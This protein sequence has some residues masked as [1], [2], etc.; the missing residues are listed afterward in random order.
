MLCRADPVCLFKDLPHAQAGPLAALRPAPLWQRC[1]FIAPGFFFQVA[2]SQCKK[3][4]PR[5]L[6]QWSLVSGEGQGQEVAILCV[7]GDRAEDTGCITM[8]LRGRAPLRGPDAI[9]YLCPLFP[10]LLVS[11]WKAVPPGEANLQYSLRG[12]A[13]DFREK[14]NSSSIIL[15]MQ[16]LSVGKYSTGSICRCSWIF[17]LRAHLLA[18]THTL[19]WREFILTSG[20]CAV[21]SFQNR[22]NYTVLKQRTDDCAPW[23]GEVWGRRWCGRL[24]HYLGDLLEKQTDDTTTACSAWISSK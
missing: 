18:P 3:F 17:L 16:C 8:G 15:P 7:T 4:T 20:T 13:A 14:L 21:L 19:N 12:E 23:A 9:P 22:V 11:H 5:S 24:W 10:V 6:M 1:A 2:V